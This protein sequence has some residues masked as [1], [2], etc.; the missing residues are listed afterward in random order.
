MKE[1][2]DTKNTPFFSTIFTVTS[3]EPYIVP[4]EFEGKFPKGTLPMHQCVGYTD[5]AF[6]QFFESAENEEWFD[7]TIFIITAD[8]TNQVGYKEYYKPINRYAIPIMIYSP[9]NKYT[10]LNSTLSQQIDIYPT[11]LDIVGYDKPFRSW[12]RSLV[13]ES[14]TPTIPFAMNFNGQNYQYS[15]GNLICIFDGVKAIGFYDVNDLGLET[16]L[17]SN[18][19]KLMD[20]VELSCKAF[21]KDYFDRI[22]DKNL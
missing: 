3:H 16:N 4:V 2:I 10:G 9:D 1:T 5:F 17:I 18:R 22:V 21:L 12:G 20:D 11:I 19:T 7:N 14:L 15:K 13:D 8:H 6:K